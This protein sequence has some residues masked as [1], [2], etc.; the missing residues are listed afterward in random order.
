MKSDG[1]VMGI[2]FGSSGVRLALINMLGEQ[3]HL[4]KVA[5][6]IGLTSVQDWQCSCKYLIRNLPAELRAK[7]IAIAVDGTSGTLLACN[8]FGVPSQ[9]ALP[10]FL[11]CPEQ[12]SKIKALVLNGETAASSSGS[13]AR[14]LRLIEKHGPNILLRHQAD[15]IT[16]WLLSDWRWGEE[17]NNLR[18]GWNLIKRSWPETYSNLL[19]FEALPDVVPSGSILSNISPEQAKTLD[20]PKE[21]LII[22]GTTDSNAAVLGAKPSREEG[23]TVLGSTI[24]LKRYVDAPLKGL[25]IT[26]H[27]LGNKWICGGAS[28]AGGTLLRKI[29]SDSQLTELS[30]Q[31]N[32]EVDTGLLFTPLPSKGERFPFHDPEMQPVIEPRP[33]SD[34]L[35]LHGLLE[36]LARIEAQ[37]WRKLSDL[38]VPYPT[39][40]LTI[41]GGAKNP[42]WRRIRERKLE[43][44]VLS[45]RANPAEGVA[46]LAL[47]TISAI[48]KPLK[49]RKGL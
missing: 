48:N 45:C 3:V 27:R 12:A 6:K 21:V 49:N 37:G 16:G 7:V 42:Q 23:V 34:S 29:F 18:L 13:L 22:S 17:G 32:P 10:Y 15:W 35:Y 46:H 40:I 19:W 30:K 24:V 4:S 39:K 11:D 25:G 26:N 31:I 36:G 1:L 5:Y 33:I 38:G 2:D 44:P 9:D 47:K 8:R 20:L 43:I 28:N 14:A 41:G